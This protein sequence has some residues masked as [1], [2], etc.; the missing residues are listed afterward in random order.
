VADIEV[1]L[2]EDDVSG[3]TLFSMFCSEILPEAHILVFPSGEEALNY[4]DLSQADIVILDIYLPGMD[5]FEFLSLLRANPRHFETAVIVHTSSDNPAA[6]SRAIELGAN[7]FWRKKA[8]LDG[9]QEQCRD[10]LHLAYWCS[11]GRRI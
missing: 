11:R 8:T 1:V 6:R 2:I 5:G 3:A 9:F 4:L 10:M 7:G